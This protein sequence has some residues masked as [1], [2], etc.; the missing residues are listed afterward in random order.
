MSL[1]SA[2]FDTSGMS[3]FSAKLETSGISLFEAKPETSGISDFLAG[4]TLQRSS[5]LRVLGLVLAV[6]LVGG[7]TLSKSHYTSHLNS[8]YESSPLLS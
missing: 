4:W 2:K 6:T 1:F 5:G 7:V 8:Q 3:L